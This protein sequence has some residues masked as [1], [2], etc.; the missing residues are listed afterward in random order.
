MRTDYKQLEYLHP[1]LRELLGWLE[2]TTGLEFTETSSYRVGEGSVHNTIPCRGY[3]LR[4]RNQRIGQAICDHIN[5][6]WDY[7]A[8]RPSIDCCVLHGEGYNLHL[9]LQVHDKTS[10]VS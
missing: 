1:K 6:H 10:H 4:C 8:S 7:D 3:D 2:D 5:L 9:H